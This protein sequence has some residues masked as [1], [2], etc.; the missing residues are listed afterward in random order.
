VNNPKDVVRAYHESLWRD[1]D[2][3]A[4]DRY[5]A[6]DAVVRMS[7]FEGTAVDV[8]RADVDR[9]FGAF[10]AV[11]TQIDD[12]LADGAKVVLRWTTS[13]DHVGP[14]GDIPATG[15]RITMRGIDIF[16]VDGERIVECW[17][18]WDGVDVYA[19]LGVLPE[20]L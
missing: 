1:G 12:L 5:W 20:G 17:S 6:A 10:A 15:K 14:Y 13:G 8:V 9:Y 4:V 19:Q 11:E 2:L 3:G 18:M 7:G 16:R